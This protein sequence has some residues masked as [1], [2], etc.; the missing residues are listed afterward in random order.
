L[1]GGD[2]V[3]TKTRNPKFEKVKPL[4]YLHRDDIGI[5]DSLKRLNPGDEIEVTALVKVLS[6]SVDAKGVRSMETEFNRLKAKGR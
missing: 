6:K 4:L 2:I 3:A 1:K 5:P